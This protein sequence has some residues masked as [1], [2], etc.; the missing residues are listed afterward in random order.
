MQDDHTLLHLDSRRARVELPQNLLQQHSVTLKLS[1]RFQG[2]TTHDDIGIT[3]YLRFSG[4]YVRC[5]IP[6]TA[7]WGM[8][9]SDNRRTVWPEDIPKEVI[10]EMAKSRITELGQRLLGRKS[11][12]VL[13]E[14]KKETKEEPAEAPKEI[15]LELVESDTKDSTTKDSKEPKAKSKPP[16]TRIK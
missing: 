13:Q 16:L 12:P 6:W 9:A 8:S 3:T 10:F 11:P 7:V 2:E 14:A 5:I 15:K 1:Y 4:E